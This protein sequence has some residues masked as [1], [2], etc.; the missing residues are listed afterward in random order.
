MPELSGLLLPGLNELA[1][2]KLIL[3]EKLLDL[4]CAVEP[5]LDVVD[6][7]HRLRFPTPSLTLSMLFDRLCESTGRRRV[8]GDVETD[9]EKFD[10]LFTTF[11]LICGA[12]GGRE[13]D[14]SGPIGPI[15]WVLLSVE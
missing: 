8:S 15:R 7:D 13:I 6:S 3:L 14:P 2:P 5:L 10:V 9:F 12:P 1:E 11:V 4:V